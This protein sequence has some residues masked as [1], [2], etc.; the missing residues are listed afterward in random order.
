M[1]LQA[2]GKRIQAL[3]EVHGLSKAQLAKKTGLHFNTI[4]N[5]EEGV[6]DDLKLGTL[7]GVARALGVEPAQ[8]LSRTK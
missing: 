1:D 6:G 7:E 8:L 4:T 3:R 5:L 2:I